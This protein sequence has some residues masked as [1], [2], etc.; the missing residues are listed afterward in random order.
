[1]GKLKKRGDANDDEVIKVKNDENHLKSGKKSGILTNYL[2]FVQESCFCRFS[3]FLIF[4]IFFLFF[5]FL[6]DILTNNLA[7]NKGKIMHRNRRC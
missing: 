4:Q 3:K 6:N 5:F 2:T 1:M 7:E